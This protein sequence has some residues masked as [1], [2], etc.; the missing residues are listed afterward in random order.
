MRHLLTSR[1]STIPHLQTLLLQLLLSA[2]EGFVTC[3]HIIYF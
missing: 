1:N 2:Y 3:V